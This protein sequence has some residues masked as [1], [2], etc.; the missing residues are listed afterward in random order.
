VGSS[1]R[2]VVVDG[3]RREFG[4]ADRQRRI[5]RVVRLWVAPCD[6]AVVD[7]ISLSGA[8]GYDSNRV[9]ALPFLEGSQSNVRIIRLSPGQALPPHRHGSSD[10]M[11]FAVEGEGV[12][13]TDGGT[14]GF[15]AGC[16]AFYRG[17]EELRV[18]NQG[19]T[20]L[21]LLAFLA[22]PFPPRSET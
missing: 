11:L 19:R 16:L 22:P 4:R 8:P 14:V 2:T 9:V 12:L 5:G 13:E 6:A 15:A 20:G 21:T 3:S 7:I 17:D 10:L 1:A 18:S